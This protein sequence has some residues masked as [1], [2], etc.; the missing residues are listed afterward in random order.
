M[1]TSRVDIVYR[2]LRIAWVI[3]A[4]DFEAFRRIAKLSCTLAG[5][6]FNPIIIVDD[7]DAVRIVESFRAD[8]VRPV[9]DAPELKAFAEKFPHLIEPWFGSG[10][11]HYDDGRGGGSCH[12][13][14]VHNLL[15]RWYRERE[16]RDIA[17][18]GLR[19]FVWSDDDPLKDV[20]LIEHGMFPPQQ[21]VFTD[22][23]TVL[24]NTAEPDAIIDIA[25]AADQPIPEE[26]AK[27][28]SI[29]M[30]GRFGVR[31]Y[32]LS[33]Y[34]GWDYPGFFAGKADDLADLVTFWN[35]RAADV[36]IRFIDLR[37][38][39]RYAA[40]LPIEQADMRQA[41]AQR[42]EFRRQV[43]LWSREELGEQAAEVAKQ[44]V[45][46]GPVTVATVREHFWNGM[47]MKPPTMML[48]DATSLGVIMQGS[49]KATASFALGDKPFSEDNWFH[50]QKLVASLSMFRWQ[51]DKEGTFQV[52]FVP[53]LNEPMGRTSNVGYAEFRA[54]PGRIGVV[55]DATTTDESVA[56]IPTLELV[57]KLFG[58][59]G[60]KASLSN[61]GLITRQLITQMGGLEDT[62]AF[63]IPG[64]RRLIRTSGLNKSVKRVDA[65]KLIGGRDP[66]N[67]TAN[68]KDHKRLF[69]E[70]RPI[71]SDLQPDDVF[72][73]LVAKRIFRIGAD[74]LCPSCRLPSWVPLDELKQT[75]T[76]SL[77]GADIDMTR[78]LADGDLTFRRS[79]LLGIEK[80][81]QGAIP[82]TMTLQ[83]LSNNVMRGA[84]R[85]AILMPSL[86]IQAADGSW[87][88]P[89]EIDFFAVELSP[90]EG[91]G[92]E[93]RTRIVIG[94]AKDRG[95]GIDANDAETMKKVAAAFPPERFRVYIVFAKLTAFTEAEIA[96]ASELSQTHKV[97]LLT[98][99]ELEPYHIYDRGTDALKKLRHDL[100]DLVR[101]TRIQY[102]TLQPPP[103]NPKVA[104]QA[105]AKGKPDKAAKKKAA[106][107]KA[108]KAKA[109]KPPKA[110]ANAK[111]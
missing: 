12:L 37:Y 47:N 43:A 94:E 6:R 103:F 86:E 99:Q 26:A 10:E 67:P 50:M 35:L 55:I 23:A 54:E 79:G 22:Y 73:H 31:R 105:A 75:V 53:E 83:Q 58:A 3:K 34:N 44:I 29:A 9:G 81:M 41:V 69:I 49:D 106:G 36:R 1:D 28:P 76:C 33:D 59:F 32:P 66:E 80:N 62:R 45:G 108:A 20:L 84:M 8:V 101:G 93:R 90:H 5:G 24:M 21:E 4:G 92:R 39:P 71:N 82:V 85:G 97:I 61:A 17:E 98:D 27:H 13:L 52:P 77:C 96:V 68:F 11:L 57:E 95:S 100:D 102:P 65:I 104:E 74:A 19:R 87:P 51:K 46:D 60:L 38:M 110:K 14:D 70:A 2:P 48:G 40:V 111:G 72:S 30:M 78:Q 107:K 15:A 16:W 42:E 56:A 64:V 89:R 25:I 63:K 88:A 91:M 18:Y 7:P 109:S